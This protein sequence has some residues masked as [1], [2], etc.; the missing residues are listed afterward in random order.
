MM[1]QTQ[2][3]AKLDGWWFLFSCMQRLGGGLSPTRVDR[4]A[5][6]GRSVNSESITQWLL[7]VPFAGCCFTLMSHAPF[8]E[9]LVSW[10]DERG[11]DIGFFDKA[12]VF[13]HPF[14]WVFSKY[15]ASCRQSDIIWIRWVSNWNPLTILQSQ[16][17]HFGLQLC[18]RTFS[19][20]LNKLEWPKHSRKNTLQSLVL[21]PTSQRP[22]CGDNLNGNCKI[23]TIQTHSHAPYR[24]RWRIAACIWWICGL[25]FSMVLPG[26]M[27]RLLNLPPPT[28][29]WLNNRASCTS[30]KG[31]CCLW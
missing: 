9:G 27:M 25:E 6:S 3:N 11:Y 7:L 4:R 17:S 28:S 31:T 12:E 5:N 2:Y 26:Q 30:L 13:F 23:Q 1:T 16:K 20:P 29:V 15:I 21:N 19:D 10:H 14:R 8:H 22:S 24:Y 18:Q